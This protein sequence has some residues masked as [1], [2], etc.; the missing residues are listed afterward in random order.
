MYLKTVFLVTLLATSVTV[1]QVITGGPKIDP[2]CKWPQTCSTLNFYDQNNVHLGWVHGTNS[3]ISFKDV[4]MVDTVGEHGCYTIYQ[5]R[6]SKGLSLCM[7][8]MEKVTIGS[9]DTDYEKTVVK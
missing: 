8:K 7:A 1:G 9:R 3:S 2:D 4:A 6:K 5:R